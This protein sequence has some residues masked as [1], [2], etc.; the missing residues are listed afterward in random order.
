MASE[1]SDFTS[2]LIHFQCFVFLFV[3]V[4]G[5]LVERPSAYFEAGANFVTCPLIDYN[6]I[7]I[8]GSLQGKVIILY[9]FVIVNKSHKKTKKTT[10]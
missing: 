10:N 5:W 2:N 3:C 8:V 7:Y 9:I 6:Q 4:S 1:S